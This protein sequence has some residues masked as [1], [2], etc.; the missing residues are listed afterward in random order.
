MRGEPSD[1]YTA[2]SKRIEARGQAWADDRI[3]KLQYRKT[4]RGNSGTS[5]ESFHAPAGAVL[6]GFERTTF[7]DLQSFYY[8]YLQVYDP[9]RG[10]IGF[11]G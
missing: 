6:T 9:I 5:V 4:S 7:G 1:A 10:W 8:M 3:Q 2:I 11:S